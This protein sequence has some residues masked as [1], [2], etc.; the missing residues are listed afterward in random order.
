MHDSF[1][2]LKIYYDEP[3]LKMSVAGRFLVRSIIYSAYGILIAAAIIFSTSAIP[4]LSSLGWLIV[5]FVADRLLHFGRA[6]RSFVRLPK[7][8][9]NVA[10]YAIP[11]V[12][13]VLEWSFDRALA[14]GGDFNLYV[15]RKLLQNK[16]VVGG[17]ARM[18]VKSD[19]FI[20]KVE[21]QLLKLA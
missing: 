20:S 1:S 11:Q 3:R 9:V 8:D 15:M 14:L 12:Y 10:L 5:L 16:D 21:G 7:E 2:N 17:L 6:E 4:W 19:E 18:D 13:S